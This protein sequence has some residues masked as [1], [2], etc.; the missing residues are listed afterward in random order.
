MVQEVDIPLP[1]D[2]L[3][4]HVVQDV[5]G[6]GGR[7]E[8]AGGGGGQGGDALTALGIVQGGPTATPV[9]SGHGE[10]GTGDHLAPL[11]SAARQDWGTPS[12]LFKPLHEEFHFL[13]DVAA[14][15]ATAKALHYLGPDHPDPDRRDALALPWETLPEVEALRRCH[16][17]WACWLW[18]NPP[19][20]RQVAGWLR[21]AAAARRNGVGVVVLLPARTDC[22]WF[23]DEVVPEAEIR[24]LRGRVRFEGGKAGAPFPSLL[25]VFRPEGPGARRAIKAM[26]W[27]IER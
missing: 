24:F 20:G 19:Y 6:S 2:P 5:G 14:T 13:T 16:P 4:A 3:P 27:E 18:C 11:F 21:H 15:A 23:H 12:T 26:T 1:F 8:R 10:Q 9:P 17:A 25:A 7:R 22:A